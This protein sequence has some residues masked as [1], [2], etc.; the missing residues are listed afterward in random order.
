[1]NPIQWLNA[2]PWA[3]PVLMVLT[4]AALLVQ[5]FA[6]NAMV[7][8]WD[9][10]ALAVLLT[11]GAGSVGMSNSGQVKDAAKTAL[12]LLGLGFVL[13]SSPA[14]AQ[15][16]LFSSG[17][18]LPMIELRPGGQHLSLA[19]GAGYQVSLSLPSLQKAF[20]GKAWDVVSLTGYAFGTDVS[21][22]SGSTF[23]ALS[24]AAGL[25]FMSGLVGVAVG[26]DLVVSSGQPSQLFGLLALSFNID[27]A[28]SLPSAGAPSTAGM[29]RGNTLY[30]GHW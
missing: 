25:S 12:L 5:E 14:R 20:L 19:A 23:G 18:T 3:R 2:Q 26:H 16:V 6:T 13:A 11:L 7:L 28:P 21:A 22:S 17:P 29:P 1:M 30:L 27:L 8:D 4:G 15:G 9:K 10:K 24:A